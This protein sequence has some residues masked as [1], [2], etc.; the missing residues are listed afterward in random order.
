MNAAFTLGHFLR[1]AHSSQIP[2]GLGAVPRQ[3]SVTLATAHH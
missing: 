3:A 2:L 1:M